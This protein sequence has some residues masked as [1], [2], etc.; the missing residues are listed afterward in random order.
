MGYWISLAILGLYS[1]ILLLFVTG[2]RYTTF[3][4]GIL[5]KIALSLFWPVLLIIYPRFRRNFQRALERD[6]SL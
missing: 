6:R 2:Y 4:R 5:V 3:P 1:A